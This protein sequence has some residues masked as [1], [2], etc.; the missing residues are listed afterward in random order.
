MS[1][2]LCSDA[3]FLFWSFELNFWA[4]AWVMSCCG[5]KQFAW[6]KH[7]YASYSFE[8]LHLF[9]KSCLLSSWE[10]ILW[11]FF[12]RKKICQNP[13]KKE[14]WFLIFYK[15]CQLI[16][17]AKALVSFFNDNFFNAPL[18]CLSSNSEPERRNCLPT[19]PFM[20]R[21]CTKVNATFSAKPS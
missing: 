12:C 2:P 13:L 19:L 20:I 5:L 17:F 18:Y 7:H 10:G 6:T 11:R 15:L 8:F 16:I 21:S 4:L 9:F 14:N 3:P 1:L